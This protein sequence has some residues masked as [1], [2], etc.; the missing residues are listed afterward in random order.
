[1]SLMNRIDED[2]KKAMKDKDKFK[3]SVIRM[4]RSSIKYVE[5][6]KRTTLSDEEILDVLTREIKQRRDSLQDFEKANR[7]DL[8]EN[9]QAELD[10]L[11]D[12]LPKQ[13]SEDELI[14]I[15]KEA[16]EEVGAKS[17]AEMGKVMS[18]V[19]PKV[20]GRADGKLINTL[21]QEYLS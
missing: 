6:E 16:I 13:L 2:M 1:M 19:M 15:I 10:I 3:L 11:K 18:A 7:N 12:Y 5:I 9:V 4:I 17:K 8:V 14:N 20:K 21:V